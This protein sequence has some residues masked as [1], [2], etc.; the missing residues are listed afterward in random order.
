MARQGKKSR[1]GAFWA[2]ALERA[3]LGV[4]DWDLRTGDCFYSPTWARMLG[5]EEDELANTS[6]LWLQLTH[7][8]DRERALASGDRHIAGLTDAIETELRLKHKQGHWVWVLDRGG[9]VERGADG[10]PLRLMGVQT[11]ISKQKAAEAAL[12]QVNVRF[13]LA[14]AASGTGIWH[15]DIAT[16]KSYWDARTRDIFGLVAD[17]D[18]VTADLWHSCLHP[19]DKEAT[20][21]AHLPPPG[22]DAVTAWQYRIIKRDGEIRHVESLVR[23]VAAAGDEL[24]SGSRAA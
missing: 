19:D 2:K 7:P 18:E 21:R 23:F 11:D 5:Y 14:L 22:S 8:D 10:R 17:T 20:E 15:H 4:W 16:H 1:N 24:L 12:E 13:R 9:I 6:D 3:H